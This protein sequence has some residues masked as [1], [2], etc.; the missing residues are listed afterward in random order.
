MGS[1]HS[2]FGGASVMRCDSGCTRAV[3]D[4]RWVFVSGSNG[5]DLDGGGI[6]EDVMEQA[7]QAFRSL[8]QALDEVDASLDDVVRVRV[9]L[10]DFRDMGRVAPVLGAYFADSR[11]ARSTIT[12]PLA[13]PR[14]KIEIE[15]T[16]RR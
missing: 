15:V 5:F 12:C 7:H 13:D 10:S 4:G 6:S 8:R 16:A 14:M 9:Y 2:T 11:P 1:V 3:I